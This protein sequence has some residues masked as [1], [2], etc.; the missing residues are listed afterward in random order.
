MIKSFCGHDGSGVMGGDSRLAARRVLQ[1]NGRREFNSFAL[2][3]HA[4]LP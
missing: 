1:R 2:Q 3:S 4:C